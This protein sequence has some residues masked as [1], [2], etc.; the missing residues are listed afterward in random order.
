MDHPWALA[1]LGLG[2]EAAL[3]VYVVPLVM[4]GVSDFRTLRIPNW[5]T[6]AL[7]LAFPIGALAAGQPV[8]WLSHVVAGVAVFVVAAVLFALR[9]M[10]GGDVK[11]LA[12]TALWIGLGQL[13]PFLVLVAL[14]GGVFA[15]VC[16]VL[17][18]PF[19]Q[20][21]ILATLRRLP[22]FAHKNLPIP[23]G[24]PIAVAGVLMAPMLPIFG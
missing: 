6:G 18:H 11:L 3:A 8:D 19:V 4:A 22:A 14:V 5:L 16:V 23:Y 20:A 9:L 12:A 13:L 2:G 7:A 24:I 10:G 15:I 21:T 1:R 17:R